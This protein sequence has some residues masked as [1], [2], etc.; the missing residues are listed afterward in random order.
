M[1]IIRDTSQAVL[2][3]DI[4]IRQYIEKR[5]A[6]LLP[7]TLEELGP[8]LVVEPTDD[9][10]AI[11]AACEFDVC[12]NHYSGKHYNDPDFLPPWESIVDYGTFHSILLVTGQDGSG[13]ELIVPK[14]LGLTEL[15][16]MC[17][18][19]AISSEH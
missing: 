6:E 10:Q 5:I 12:R 2:V 1:I 18:L 19:Y 17:R 15:L 14:T 11:N 4:A 9:L 13:V 7:Y 8:I 3:T 16:E